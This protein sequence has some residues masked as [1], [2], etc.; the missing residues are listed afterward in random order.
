MSDTNGTS[1]LGGNHA[2]QHGGG[3]YHSGSGGGA[4]MA[5]DV[6][7]SALLIDGNSAGGH[8]GGLYSVNQGSIQ[9]LRNVRLTG[10]VALGDGGGWY[11]DGGIAFAVGTAIEQQPEISNNRSENGR[12]GGVY[13]HDVASGPGDT[14]PLG[15][16][17]ISGNWADSEGGGLYVAAS[18]HVLLVNAR[19]ENNQAGQDGGGVL[20]SAS[21]LEVW[22]HPDGCANALLPANQYCSEFRNNAA[23]A[24][25]GA[26]RLELGRS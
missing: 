10:N 6:P 2:G 16:L 26:I 23:P 24:S 13:L 5:E 20:A 21:H 12:G 17:T 19:V 22:Q 9:L 14:A 25:G 11:Q 15:N 7:G 3:Y 4:F 8:G 1:R 18:S